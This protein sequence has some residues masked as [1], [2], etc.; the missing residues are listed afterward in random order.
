MVANSFVPLGVAALLVVALLP[1][2]NAINQTHIDDVEPP[3]QVDGGVPGDERG[4][5]IE[6]PPVMPD[7]DGPSCNRTAVTEAVYAQVW[8]FTPLATPGSAPFIVEGGAA[9]IHGIVNLTRFTG[10]I[11]LEVVRPDGGEAGSIDV[12]LAPTPRGVAAPESVEA[13]VEKPGP[14]E[15]SLRW[16]RHILSGEAQVLFLV[17]YPCGKLPGGVPRA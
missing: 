2:F 13:S 4:P 1:A 10:S 12:S 11:A 16:N 7:P 8:G 9:V 17:Y 14:G 6:L 5:A 15:W 3:L